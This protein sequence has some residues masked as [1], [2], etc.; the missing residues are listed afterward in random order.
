MLRAYSNER[1]T[2][3]LVVLSAFAFL[4]PVGSQDISRLGL[5][6]SIALRGSLQID[7]YAFG[8]LTPDRSRYDGH[9]Y[10]DKAPGMS[11]LALPAFEL[12]RATGAVGRE[13]QAHGIWTSRDA[14]W[15]LRI[16]TGGVVFLAGILVV[17]RIAEWLAPSTGAAV[18]LALGLG[19]MF[20]PLAATTFSHVAAGTFSFLAFVFAWIGGGSRRLFHWLVSG[21]SAGLACLFEYGSVL[22]VAI[23]LVYLVVKARRPRAVLLYA[24]GA[25]PALAALAL[26]QRLAFGSPFHLPYRYIANEYASRQGE[27]IFGVASPHPSS[28]FHVVF[29]LRGLFFWSPLL[30]VASV[31]LVLLARRG[32]LLEALTCAAVAVFFLVYDAGYFDPYGGVSPGPRFFVPAIPFLV[33]GLVEAYRR[34]RRPTAAFVLVSILG[35]TLRSGTWNRTHRFDTIWSALGTSVFVGAVVV[36]ATALLAAA[37]ALRPLFRQDAVDT[38]I[39]RAD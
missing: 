2:L 31:G 12:L 32:Y 28:L 3:L 22:A 21:V 4:Y 9:Y 11:L 1:K 17:G 34:W 8:T 13:Q 15:W 16:A 19:T 39:E 26:Y 33:L 35:M 18:A 38:A 23:V 37:V 30:A 25:S 20:E 29:G 36:F 24:V 14:L 27:G 5:T 10:S 6:Q 7:G